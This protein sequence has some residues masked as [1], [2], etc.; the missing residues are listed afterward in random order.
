MAEDIFRACTENAKDLKRQRKRLLGLAN[1]AIREK[2]DADLNSLTKLYAL[3]YSAYAEVS[4]LKLI[5]TPNAFGDSEITQIE[6]GRNLEEKW[7]KCVELAFKKLNT[8]ANL[9]EIANKKRTL[10]KIQNKYIIAPSLIRNKV[11]HGQ[12][13]VCL[14]NDCSRINTDATD[15]M[16]Q[17]DFVKIDRLFSIYERFQQCILDLAISQRTHYRDYYVIITSLDE[18]IDSTRDWSLESKKQKIL[19]SL[20]QQRYENRKS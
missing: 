17:L 8:D 5:H 19:S 1:R 15:E 13:I 4:L 18:Y 2:N 9:G 6:N 3:L 16:K 11:A 14:N 20:K 10:T 12:W 7:K